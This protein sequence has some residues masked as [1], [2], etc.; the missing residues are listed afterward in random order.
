[1]SGSAVVSVR[2]AVES[3]GPALSRLDRET[4][5]ARV[6]P[7]P[8]PSGEPDFFSAHCLP[9]DHLVGTMAGEVVGYVAWERPTSLASN[10]HVRHICGLAVTPSRQGQGIGR[11]LI[12]GALVELS[13]RGVT[14][15][16]LRVLAGNE[17]A[18]ALYRS[19]GFETEGVLR[20]EFRL[21]GQLVDD[22]FMARWL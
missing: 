19:C 5:S 8:E 1:M 20:G 11:A 15:V 3:D 18:L 21:A 14:K 13:T 6:S 16:G 12:E 10:A 17:P 2:A 9:G 7:S 22:L 4:R